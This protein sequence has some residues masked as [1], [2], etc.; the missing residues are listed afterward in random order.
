[1]VEIAEAARLCDRLED[2]GLR[3]AF[4]LGGPKRVQVAIRDEHGSTVR[5]LHPPDSTD[6]ERLLQLSGL[7]S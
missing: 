1:A 6:V 4:E 3:I 7:A 5:E 2:A